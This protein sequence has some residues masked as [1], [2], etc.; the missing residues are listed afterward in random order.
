MAPRKIQLIKNLKAWPFGK[1][2]T[3]EFQGKRFKDAFTKKVLF[4]PKRDD[5]ICL[6]DPELATITSE[7]IR[8]RASQTL[9]NS[10]TSSYAAM[11]EI[12]PEEC[13]F[14]TTN[15]TYK[16]MMEMKRKLTRQYIAKYS[17]KLYDVFWQDSDYFSPSNTVRTTK[18]R[19]RGNRLSL[20]RDGTREV[21]R[22]PTF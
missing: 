14:N 10:H 11:S 19:K 8:R 4:E 16:D 18:A 2:S 1:H 13:A 12:E 7:R 6:R 5:K 20:T 17:E 3:E 21:L 15:L 22:Q 9:N